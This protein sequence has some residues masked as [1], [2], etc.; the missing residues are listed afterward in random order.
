MTDFN[1]DASLVVMEHAMT[2][3]DT[4]QARPRAILLEAFAHTNT[5]KNNAHHESVVKRNHKKGKKRDERKVFCQRNAMCYLE[6]S[7]Q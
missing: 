1:W 7:N 2:G 5:K 3:R 6:R 4:P